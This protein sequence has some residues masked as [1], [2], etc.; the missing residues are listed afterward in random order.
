[1]PRQT[2]TLIEELLTLGEKAL[3]RALKSRKDIKKHASH[4]LHDIA[5]KMDLVTRDE[6][7]SAMAMISKART[8]QEDLKKR[9]AALESKMNLSSVSKKV[10]PKKQSLPSVKHNKRRK[11]S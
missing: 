1:M 11:K 2:A 3:E 9:V 5:Q 7:D 6:F 8:I 4:H 10:T